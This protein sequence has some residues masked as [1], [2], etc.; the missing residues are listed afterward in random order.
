MNYII[1][2]GSAKII[3]SRIVVRHGNTN[4][5]VGVPAQG[6]LTA[7]D[8]L[9]MS[10]AACVTTYVYLVFEKMRIDFGVLVSVESSVEKRPGEDTVSRA[11]VRVKLKSRDEK[12]LK[13]VDYAVRTCPVG[14]LLSRAGV[15]VVKEYTV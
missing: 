15:D 12:A 7:L 10:L 9:A 3:D 2:R 8:L 13:A 6:S 1:G 14:K 5:E 11:V 4:V